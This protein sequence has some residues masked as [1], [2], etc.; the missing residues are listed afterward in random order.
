MVSCIG[1]G[2][3]GFTNKN[4]IK[5][6][7]YSV[8]TATLEEGINFIDTARSYY[9]S[10]K[11]VGY[12][13]RQR[14]NDCFIATKTFLRDADAVRKEID[15]SLR[16]LQVKKIDLY[17]IHHVQYEYE[18]ERALAKD[19]ALAALKK[20]RAEGKISYIGFSSHRPE[21]AIKC[22]KSGEFDTAQIP[23]NL[24][25][26]EYIDE[27]LL[28]A[29]EHDVGLIVMKPLAG[30]KLNNVELALRF[31]LSYD[32]AVVIPGCSTVEQVRDNA[33]IGRNFLPL[34]GQEKNDIFNELKKLNKNFCRRCRY[35]EQACPKKIPIPDIFRCE[36]HILYDA[37]YA[38]YE[39]KRFRGEIKRCIACKEC[40]KI[41]PYNLPV[42]AM[43][44]KAHKRLMGGRIEDR[45]VGLLRILR[46]YEWVKKAYFQLNLPLPK[47]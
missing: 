31:V 17:Q 34:T 21:M 35:C 9:D 46:L 36:E 15:L 23:F 22:I 26:R 4:Y 18:L 30:G 33:R 2:G 10:E 45:V 20:A 24:I 41:C 11:I 40:E 14:R 28:A 12:A 29:K 13:L 32:I 5:D 7:P 25:E 38:R 19:G 37:G 47:R 39:Y 42:R 16:S 6:D 43:L 44:K 1:L 3:M 8:V 27:I